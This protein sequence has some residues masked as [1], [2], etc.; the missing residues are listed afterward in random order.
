LEKRAANWK[1]AKPV[2]KP[3]PR[4][5]IKAEIG[6]DV[7]LLKRSSELLKGTANSLAG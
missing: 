3:K 4:W 7:G 1:T 5:D 2:V 6:K